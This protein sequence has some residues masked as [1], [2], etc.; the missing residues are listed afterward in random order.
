M[1]IFA[2]DIALAASNTGRL[3][4]GGFATKTTIHPQDAGSVRVDDDAAAAG[5]RLGPRGDQG[6]VYNRDAF[7]Y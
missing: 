2:D 5:C 6:R 1:P 7:Q 3:I 4:T